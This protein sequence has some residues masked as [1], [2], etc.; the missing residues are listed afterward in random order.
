MV[1]LKTNSMSAEEYLAKSFV[2]HGVGL[3]VF[4][5]RGA[6]LAHSLQRLDHSRVPTHKH[7][8]LLRRVL[9]SQAS[10]LVLKV[11]S[12][13]NDRN[14][15]GD[16]P[17]EPHHHVD[18]CTPA[19]RPLGAGDLILRSVVPTADSLAPEEHLGGLAV[20]HLRQVQVFRDNLTQLPRPR[21][22]R[23]QGSSKP[24]I[25]HASRAPEEM[26][27]TRRRTLVPCSR[28]LNGRTQ[29]LHHGEQWGDANTSPYRRY[30]RVRGASF[31]RGGD[32]PIQTNPHGPGRGTGLHASSNPRRIL[33]HHFHQPRSE[34]PHS[35][36]HERHRIF[37]AAGADREIVPL[38]RD[39]RHAHARVHPRPAFAPPPARRLAEI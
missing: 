18:P 17:G 29:R 27:L 24:K 38:L 12:A 15:P 34:I 35:F 1:K 31:E 14:P 25:I 16:G 3:P 4:V 32:G 26:R 39:L 5:L 36:N 23:Q 28:R 6:R 19:G 2:V 8:N 22:T 13:Q 7:M 30:D 11:G 21:D 9:L 20:R 10:N 33:P 37:P